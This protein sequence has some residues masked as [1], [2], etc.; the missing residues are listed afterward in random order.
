MKV[1]SS[2][3]RLAGALF[4]AMGAIAMSHGAVLAGI[5]WGG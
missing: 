5:R 3:T 1:R 4:F 2:L